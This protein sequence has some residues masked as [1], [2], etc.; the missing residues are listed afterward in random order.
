MRT[1]DV[2][3]WQRWDH[4][5]ANVMTLHKSFQV[6]LRRNKVLKLKWMP[7]RRYWSRCQ[8]HGLASIRSKPC[9]ASCNRTC[10][11]MMYTVCSSSSGLQRSLRSFKT[12]SPSLNRSYV[13]L[14]RH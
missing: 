7:R 5:F 13:M 9:I 10:R 1:N 2:N 14:M 12:N 3:C 4:S 8:S 11:R 6:L